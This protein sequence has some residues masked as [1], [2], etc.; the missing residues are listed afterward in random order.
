MMNTGARLGAFRR[1]TQDFS[2][3]AVDYVVVGAG[4]A[5]CVMAS[6]L[7]EKGH[8]VK[9]LEAGQSDSV[10]DS[11]LNLLLHMPTA[12][13]MPM[14]RDKFNWKFVVNPEEALGG[15]VIHCPRGKGLGGSSS[16]NGL[17]Y[18]RG[19]KG[20]FDAWEEMGATGWNY[21]S[22]LP[23]FRKAENW[24]G[25]DPSTTKYRGTD[26]PLHVKFGE[27]SHKTPLFDAFIE[28][29]SQAGYGLTKD[30][31][32]ARQEG[33][34]PK[35]MTVF[36][37]GPMKGLRCSTSSAYLHPAIKEYPNKIDVETGAMIQRVLWDDPKKDS[38]PRAVGVE[39]RDKSGLIQSLPAAKEVIL[40]AGAIG[41]PQILQ[42]SGVGDP[43]HLKRIGVIDSVEQII[44][45]N[46]NVGKNLTDHLELYFQQEVV[47][48]VSIAPIVKS[49]IRKL[50]VGIEWVLF[51][52]GLG[53]TNHFESAA[54]VRSSQTHSYPD[55]QFHF[56][57]VAVSYDGQTIAESNSGHSMQVSELTNPPPLPSSFKD[58]YVPHISPTREPF[59]FISDRTDP[60]HVD[61]CLLAVVAWMIRPRYSS[62]TC[63]NP[64]NGT[65]F[66]RQL[67][68]LAKSCA[69]LR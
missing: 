5:G 59:R 40:C 43:D 3:P 49:W 12:L 24:H 67:R 34:G 2:K 32:A 39:Y 50:A 54:F 64:R 20:D 33:F 38:K 29:G 30:Y 19:N 31:N 57:P 1:F 66:V 47:L 4:S 26:G 52:R 63:P 45:A 16:I 42:V 60:C 21:A 58:K 23:Y 18:V 25:Q 6:R 17:V 41:S 44:V 8:T 46:P 27:N 48:P 61:T 9:L 10:L 13:A 28:A 65:I 15:R 14:H 51:R 62:I 55:I 11:P 68:L 56:L 53:A 7:A 22:V 69:S 37:S 36:H 35:A